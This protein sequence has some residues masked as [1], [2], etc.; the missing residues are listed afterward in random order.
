ML[1]NEHDNKPKRPWR[2]E[3]GAIAVEFAIAAPL[4]VLLFFGVLE[5]GGLLKTR[6]QL[7]DASREGA[8]VAAAQPR[9]VGYQNS[10]LAAIEGIIAT[11]TGEIIDYVVIYKA[12]PATGE[13]A[14]GEAVEACNID[15]WRYERVA[16]GFEQ[17]LIATWPAANQEACG[18]VSDTDW[19]GVYIRGHH[20][21]ITGLVGTTR[22]FTDRTIMRLEPMALG[23]QCRP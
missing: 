21:F 1:N 3:R 16:G 18:G 7:T 20:D 11:S 14:S 6:S 13:P 15:C 23:E 5:M 2:N 17:K 9:E 8:R 10:S 4:L 22:T 12:D 19:I